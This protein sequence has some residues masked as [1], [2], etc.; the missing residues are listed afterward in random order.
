M[1]PLESV[2]PSATE[3][4]AG[5]PA[6][7]DSPEPV[8]DSTAAGAARP[9]RPWAWAL[10]AGI[11]AGVVSWYGGEV[12]RGHF[13]HALE[14]N[15]GPI[16]TP[17]KVAQVVADNTAYVAATY[18]LFGAVL[19]MSMGLAGGLARRAVSTG[20]LA[21]VVGMVAGVAAGA[22]MSFVVLPEYYKRFNPQD[23]DLILPILMHV[24][25]WSAMGAGGGLAFGIGMGG[26]AR[27]VRALL[28]GLL[29][30][31][32]ATLLYEVV[33]AVLLPLDKT[34]QPLA[35]TSGARLLAQLLVAVFAAAGAASGIQEPAMKPKHASPAT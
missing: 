15:V 4:P 25:I 27:P 14:P 19:G 8:V 35:A 22:G 12:L 32:A 33:G 21:I 17:E 31:I 18:G 3:P 29:G 1:E 2:P 24:G 16:P 5:A 23:V 9:R 28:G 26:A 11:L 34:S 7:S 10:T 13:Q 30:A 20:V 6:D